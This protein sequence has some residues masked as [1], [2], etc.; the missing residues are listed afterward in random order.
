MLYICIY[1][2]DTKEIKF[3]EKYPLNTIE[4][5]TWAIKNSER[6]ENE[7]ICRIPEV[8]INYYSEKKQFIFD[9]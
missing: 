1:N 7:C 5:K 6:L 4:E 9:K 2:E 3:Q 8:W